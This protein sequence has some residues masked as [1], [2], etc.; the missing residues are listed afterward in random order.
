MI[1]SP[2]ENFYRENLEK[3]S[4]A[5]LKIKARKNLTTWLRVI[6]FL[7]GVVGLYIF[8]A[9]NNSQAVIIISIVSVVLFLFLVRYFALLKNRFDYLSIKQSQFEKELQ[10]LKG[11]YSGFDGAE[12]EKDAEHEFVEDIDFFGDESVFQQI[13]RSCTVTGRSKLAQWFKNPEQNA[14]ELRKRQQAITELVEKRDL[15]FTFRATGMQADMKME[16]YKGL[17]KWGKLPQLFNKPI[18]IILPIVAIL[19]SVIGIVLVSLSKIS[20]VVFILYVFVGPMAFSSIYVQR[21]TQRHNYV[22]RMSALFSAYKALFLQV[23][24]EEFQ[25]DYLQ[26]LQHELI[27]DKVASQAIDQLGKITTAIDSRL[28]LLM[29]FVLNGLFLWDIIQMVR[30]ERWQQ[31]YKDEI[32]V[33]FDALGTF[34]A[35]CSLSGFAY[36]NPKYVLPQFSDQEHVMSATKLGHPLISAEQRVCNDFSLEKRGDFMIITGANMAGKSTF[37]RTVAVNMILGMS[38]TVVCAEK[39]IFTPIHVITSLRTTDNLVR[40]ESY[41]FA[42]L[43]RLKWIID[44]LNS[45]ERLFIILD[46]ILKGTNSKDKQEGSRALIEQLVRLKATGI[47]ATHDI[48]LGKLVEEY[49]DNIIN[50]CFE[51]DLKNDQLIF[52]YTLRA[53]VS[54]NMNATFLMRRMGITV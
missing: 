39:M 45:G 53:G 40:N 9:S 31:K 3:V 2:Q 25:S 15:R 52:D 11:D 43:K 28:N 6:I 32:P 26:K 14:N 46:E 23:E 37:L 8:T 54:Q 13:N 44:K 1:N 42:E 4:A 5:R 12:D 34:D 24:K 47:I 48:I 36:N 50:R 49:P 21:I 33:W 19:L 38:G 20:F 17:L 30:L 18:F 7:G 51:V 29:A 27:G 41:F 16:D 35:L 10:G 22:S